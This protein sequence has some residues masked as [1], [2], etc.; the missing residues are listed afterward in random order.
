MFLINIQTTRLLSNDKIYKIVN[1]SLD[2]SSDD[3]HYRLLEEGQRLFKFKTI[4]PESKLPA[5]LDGN[6]KIIIHRLAGQWYRV[7]INDVLIGS[8]GDIKKRI[9]QYLECFWCL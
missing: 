2:G 1:Y 7:Y 4:I 5:T 3:L 8:L 9:Q 6:Y